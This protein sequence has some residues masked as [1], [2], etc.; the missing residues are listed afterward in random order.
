MSIDRP[1]IADIQIFDSH[2]HII[3]PQYPLM[4]NQGY[5][6]ETFKMSDYQDQVSHLNIIG[7]SIVSG[8]F[9][10]FDQQYLIHALDKMGPTF[11]AVANLPHTTTDNQIA[12]YHNLGYRAVRFNLYRGGSETID[13]MIT[14]ARRIYDIAQWHIE[15]YIHG[16][17]L[18]NLRKFLTQLPSFSI[19]HMGLSAEGMPELMYWAEK[20]MKIKATGFG[21]LD[22]E[23][24]EWMKK[25]YSVNPE[26]LMFGTDLPSTRAPVPF[27]N[28]HI[29]SI[30]DHF[31]KKEQ[32]NIFYKNA[33]QF[34]S[35]K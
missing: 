15:L 24:S 11:Y 34:Y 12:K 7:G 3:D 28:Q 5:I 20:G 29:Q 27:S 21:R 23:P 32:E 18:Q 13:H 26:S 22:F 4:A 1:S 33:L 2:F 14:F 9:Q 16:S 19:D 31:S 35:K 30:V 8:S 25:I 17:Q 6:P 10:R